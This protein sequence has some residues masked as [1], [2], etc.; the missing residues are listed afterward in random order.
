MMESL[1]HDLQD[2]GI[3]VIGEIGV[4]EGHAFSIDSDNGKISGCL[5]IL[6]CSINVLS[7]VV[8]SCGVGH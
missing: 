3:V 1:N 5:Y 4:I 7:V 6:T 2:I 8:A